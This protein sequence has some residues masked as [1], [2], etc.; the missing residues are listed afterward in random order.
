MS[1]E[2]MLPNIISPNQ[3]LLSTNLMKF[4]A[5]CE[6]PGKTVS[7]VTEMFKQRLSDCQESS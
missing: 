4:T 6:V 1:V 5:A 3:H 7:S 2:N